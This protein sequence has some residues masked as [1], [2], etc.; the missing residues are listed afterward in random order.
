MV[1][2]KT[3]IVKQNKNKNRRDT[4]VALKGLLTQAKAKKNLLLQSKTVGAV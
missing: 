2:T 3:K 1:A 4:V